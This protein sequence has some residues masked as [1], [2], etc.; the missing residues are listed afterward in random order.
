MT[1]AAR[2]HRLLPLLVAAALLAPA[3]AADEGRL[4]ATSASYEHGAR[5]GG[6]AVAFFLS[7]DPGASADPTA[8]QAQPVAK[9][10]IRADRLEALQVEQRFLIDPSA[11]GVSQPVP[12]P[13]FDASAPPAR[14][15]LEGAHAR[16]EQQVTDLQ[17]HLIPA[18]GTCPVSAHGDAGRLDALD[19]LMMDAGA[20]R[21]ATA[22]DEDAR[23]D[24]NPAFWSVRHDGPVVRDQELADTTMTFTGDLVLEFLGGTLDARDQDEHVVLESGVWRE[25]AVPGL[26]AGSMDS[27]RIVLLRVFLTAATVRVDVLGEGAQAFL[28]SPSLDA[29]P[30]GEAHLAGASGQVVSGG[31]SVVLDNEPF[32]VP[33]GNEI[34]LR[35][36]K[37]ALDLDVHAA[38]ASV[39]AGGK[40]LSSAGLPAWLAL[41]ATLVAAAAALA[42]ALARRA[43]RTDLRAV[44]AAIEGQRFGRAAR[45]AKRVLRAQPGLEDAMLGRAIALSK[46]GRAGAAIAELHEHLARHPASDGS[47]HYVLGL[48]FLDVGRV[49]DARVALE[50]AVRL[51]PAL[52][53]DVQARLAAQA[54]SG[55][56]P[57]LREV[58]GYA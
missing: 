16:L 42:L 57:T 18:D 11:G 38:P 17:M 20:F 10:D 58:H 40:G 22:V 6:D 27:E 39:A 28:A 2:L 23:G 37:G 56:Q 5:L 36:G 35:P 8:P 1:A 4:T 46:G 32:T 53:N 43:S 33:A 9:M 54:S 44:E 31:R 19:G 15:V 26:P 50:E 55:E 7:A 25:P 45:L 48:S 30:D 52:A 34:A 14:T 3:A 24:D 47:L 21:Q 41:A 51:T 13:R 12:D 49:A 29:L